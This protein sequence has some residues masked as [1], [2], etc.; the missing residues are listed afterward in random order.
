MI[1]YLSAAAKPFGLYVIGVCTLGKVDE[2]RP[3]TLIVGVG[4]PLF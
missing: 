3:V 2:P 1:Q 4:F